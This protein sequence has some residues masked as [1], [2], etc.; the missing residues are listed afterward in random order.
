M[1]EKLEA[2][3]HR[4]DKKLLELSRQMERLNHDYFTILNQTDLTTEELSSFA[5]NP[6]NFTP[7]LWQE[8]Q[9]E[10]QKNEEQLNLKLSNVK[11]P[12]KTQQSYKERGRVQQHWLFVR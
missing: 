2:K 8:L 4:T 10:Q 9:M 12:K 5:G 7:S 6:N 1:K 11:D 3:I